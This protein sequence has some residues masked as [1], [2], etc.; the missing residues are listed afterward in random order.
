MDHY[1]RS[2]DSARANGNPHATGVALRGLAVAS[3]VLGDTAALARS[4][5]ALDLLYHLR[6]WQKAYQVL[7][8]IA[9]SLT[10]AGHLEDAAVV[11]GFLEHEL[12]HGYGMENDLGFRP[13]VLRRIE[14][15]PARLE[16]LRRG[17]AMTRDQLANFV[18][19]ESAAHLAD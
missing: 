13:V 17:A 18:L 7:E 2:L 14:H 19:T 1:S 5:E 9:Y 3:C 16:L 6:Y 12:P 10:V 8:D 4:V 11:A 15:Q